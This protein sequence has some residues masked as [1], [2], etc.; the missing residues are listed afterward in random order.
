MESAC[1]NGTAPLLSS[2]RVSTRGGDGEDG[3][4]TT[5]D[6]GGPA[7][8]S[9]RKQPGVARSAPTSPTPV[10]AWVQGYMSI[11]ESTHRAEGCRDTQGWVLRTTATPQ[12][13]QQGP[14]QHPPPST[15]QVGVY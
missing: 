5:G 1:R 15:T 4:A 14:G 2:P 13:H 7:S 12:C 6:T 11:Q 9:A 3:G 8:H 10:M